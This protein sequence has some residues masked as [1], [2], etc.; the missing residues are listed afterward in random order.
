MTTRREIIKSGIGLAGIIAAGKAPAAIVR[1]LVGAAGTKYLEDG[2]GIPENPTAA[3]YIRENILAMWDGI[4]N[5]GWGEHDNDSA[6]W[7]D[8]AGNYD[9]GLY[10]DCVWSEDKITFSSSVNSYCKRQGQF[11]PYSIKTVEVVLLPVQL[12]SNNNSYIVLAYN[13]WNGSFGLARQGETF[14]TGAQTNYSFSA[15]GYDLTIPHTI[16]YTGDNHGGTRSFYID[17]LPAPQASR[18]NFSIDWEGRRTTPPD[19]SGILF[20][21]NWVHQQGYDLYAVR[22]HSQKLTD[23]E[24]R[25]NYLID[26]MRFGLPT[27]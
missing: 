10:G 21:S 15:A 1:S 14:I 26:Q 6:I 5:V 7:K 8:L 3:D 19:G 24:I 18:P 4:E 25:Y 17:G 11:S 2:S 13:G 23:K 22:V 12:A 9:L 27:T 16:S 20:N